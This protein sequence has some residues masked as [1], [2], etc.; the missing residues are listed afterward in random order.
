MLGC[1]DAGQKIQDLFSLFQID[2]IVF[3]SCHNTGIHRKLL[4]NLLQHLGPFPL[5]ADDLQMIGFL[6]ITD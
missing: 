6:R 2:H 4:Y 1:T 5:L 3:L